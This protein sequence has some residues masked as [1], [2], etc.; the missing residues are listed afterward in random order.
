MAE[1]INP[2]SAGWVALQQFNLP[3]GSEYL[4]WTSTVS[5][6]VH[7]FGVPSPDIHS[8]VMYSSPHPRINGY[9]YHDRTA[10]F[11]QQDR[12]AIA[13]WIAI[14]PLV[15]QDFDLYYVYNNNVSVGWRKELT[16]GCRQG[17]GFC[18]ELTSGWLACPVTECSCYF[19]F[20]YNKMGHS[21][22][23]ALIPTF[24]PFVWAGQLMTGAP[25]DYGIRRISPPLCNWIFRESP[26]I[27]HTSGL[28][29]L[30]MYARLQYFI[31]EVFPCL[32][33]RYR[34]TEYPP[35][36]LNSSM[37]LCYRPGLN[38]LP[39][40][41]LW[42]EVYPFLNLS[43]R[44]ISSGLTLVN[45]LAHHWVALLPTPEKAIRA[46]LLKKKISWLRR[47]HWVGSIPWPLN[48]DLSAYDWSD[49]IGYAS[50]WS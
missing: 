1:P 7:R 2:Y 25:L 16:S 44:K 35:R 45:L 8:F 50:H 14:V 36:K 13:S 31:P 49:L 46:G 39:F 3:S 27:L 34:S 41:K 4:P 23:R 42:K 12:T 19:I 28:H 30:F 10:Y 18:S 11:Y 21:S 22:G 32:S 24:L 38:E 20:M 15:G 48:Y 5:L 37:L 33:A 29:S 17:T 26:P 9:F 43:F 6:Y 40:L 47:A